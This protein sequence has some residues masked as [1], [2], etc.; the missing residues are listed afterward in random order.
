MLRKDTK[1]YK[2]LVE[3]YCEIR[4]RIFNENK[5]LGR[6]VRERDE[7]VAHYESQAVDEEIKKWYNAYMDLLTSL[8][9]FRRCNIDRLNEELKKYGTPLKNDYEE[10]LVE[11]WLKNKKE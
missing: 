11:L 4:E 10:N 1:K 8:I 2:N 7:A 3:K 9:S 6:Y 5:E